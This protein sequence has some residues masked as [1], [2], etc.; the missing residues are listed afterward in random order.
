VQD[1]QLDLTNKWVVEVLGPF[2]FNLTSAESMVGAGSL[3]SW[4]TN[5]VMAVEASTGSR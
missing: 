1:L 2:M 4:C 5:E 3:V